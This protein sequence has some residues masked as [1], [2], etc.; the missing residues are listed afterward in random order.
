MTD[1]KT[2]SDANNLMCIPAFNLTKGRPSVFKKPFGT[3]HR[4]GRFKMMDVA[5]ATSA[6]PTFLP[7]VTIEG[8]QFVDGGLFANN[9]SMIGYTEAMDHFI[10]KTHKIGNEKFYY[11]KNT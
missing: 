9:P 7:A 8:D 6:A 5:L 10:D 4:D 1:Y 2:M 3:Y 11:V